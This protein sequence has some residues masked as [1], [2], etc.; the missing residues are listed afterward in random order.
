M[1]CRT[2]QMMMMMM[3]NETRVVCMRQRQTAK[4]RNDD[5]DDDRRE[6]SMLFF[7]GRLTPSNDDRMGHRWR[8]LSASLL[9]RLSNSRSALSRRARESTRRKEKIHIRMMNELA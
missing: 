3:I 1:F 7:N 6:N 8:Y 2:G 5:D 9:G 4:R